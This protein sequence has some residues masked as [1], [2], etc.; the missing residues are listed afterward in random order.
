[1]SDDSLIERIGHLISVHVDARQVFADPIERDGTT[2]IPVAK[3]QWGFGGG[4]LGSGPIERGGGGGGV[5]A[6]P[7]GFIEIRNG[8]AVYRP[9]RDASDAL[10]LFSAALVGFAAGLVVASRSSR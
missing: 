7:A 10:I 9:C 8:E 5:R 6:T 2:V 1:M 3:M 4:G